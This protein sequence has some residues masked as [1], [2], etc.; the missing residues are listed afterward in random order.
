MTRSP[1][2]RPWKYSTACPPT[3]PAKARAALTRDESGHGPFGRCHR[4]LA[5]GDDLAENLQRRQPGREPDVGDQVHD[6]LGEL[7]G[8]DALVERPTEVALH[9]ALLA[10]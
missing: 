3:E 10:L 7:L 2:A 4:L 6:R 1:R 9:L 5:G 8:R